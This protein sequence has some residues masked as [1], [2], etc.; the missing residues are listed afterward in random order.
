MKIEVSNVDEFIICL[1]NAE[2]IWENT[3][4]VSLTRRP[5]DGNGRNSTSF[6]VNFQASALVET[7]ESGEYLLEVGEMCGKDIEDSEPDRTG[8][9]NAKKL[10]E[11]LAEYAKTRDWKILPGVISS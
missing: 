4:R 2:S 1:Q 3:L 8:S 9:E 7:T 5:I 6:H 10:K 11:K